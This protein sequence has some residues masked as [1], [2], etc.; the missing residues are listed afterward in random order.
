MSKKLV[1]AQN[2]LFAAVLKALNAAKKD[3]AL[4]QFLQMKKN[5]AALQ[6]AALRN[7]HAAQRKNKFVA[8]KQDAAK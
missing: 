6:A 1:V 2:K 8:A 4:K 7:Q 5:H 3:N